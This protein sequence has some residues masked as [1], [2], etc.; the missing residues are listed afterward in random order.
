MKFRRVE[1]VEA[2][3]LGDMALPAWWLALVS[4]GLVLDIGPSTYIG[5]IDTGVSRA[6]PGDWIVR[7]PDGSIVPVSPEAFAETYEAAL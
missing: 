3:K 4:G 5:R 1:N 2:F 7:N 6:S